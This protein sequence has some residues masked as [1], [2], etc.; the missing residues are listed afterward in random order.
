MFVAGGALGNIPDRLFLFNGDGHLTVLDFIDMGIGNV[1]WFVYN[2]ADASVVVGSIGLA[3]LFLLFEI[4]KA[5]G[6]T[7]NKP[8]V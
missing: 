6:G 4:K 5:Q 8:S 7:D 3:I 2:I 1:R